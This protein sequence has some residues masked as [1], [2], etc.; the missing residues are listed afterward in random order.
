MFVSSLLN[1]KVI[2]IQYTQR[3]TTPI[4]IW[5]RRDYLLVPSHGR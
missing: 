1:T 4:P 5:R 3:S 2:Q